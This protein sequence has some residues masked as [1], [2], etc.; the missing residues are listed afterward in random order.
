[1]HGRGR[2]A[3]SAVLSFQSLGVPAAVLRG[4]FPGLCRQELPVRRRG[5]LVHRT[6]FGYCR[7]VDMSFDYHTFFLTPAT[8]LEEVRKK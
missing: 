3:L 6:C 7:V 1:M 2:G 4:L 8:R 5:R